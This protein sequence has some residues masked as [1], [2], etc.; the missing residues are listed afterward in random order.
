VLAGYSLIADRRPDT[1]YVR[2]ATALAAAA[3]FMFALV[4]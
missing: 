1:P 2:T 4:M 3:T